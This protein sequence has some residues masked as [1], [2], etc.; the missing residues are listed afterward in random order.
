MSAGVVSAVIAANLRRKQPMHLPSQLAITVGP[1]H[2]MEVAWHDTPGQSPG[3]QSCAPLFDQLYEC[4]IVVVP[5]KDL[6]A[7]IAAAQ[8]VAANL[9]HRSSCGSRHEL[10]LPQEPVQ[11]TEKRNVPLL[12]FSDYRLGRLRL[13]FTDLLT[14]HY[15][16]ATVLAVARQMKELYEFSDAPVAKEARKSLPKT[17]K[18][19][20]FTEFQ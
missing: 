14:S 9:T 6:S 1:Q 16:R 3:R 10:V 13:T 2:E 12:V 18:R 11:T 17:M 15:D 20:G 4:L 5:V 8:H 7:R 19:A